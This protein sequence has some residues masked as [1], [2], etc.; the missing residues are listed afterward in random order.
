MAAPASRRRPCEAGKKSRFEVY[1]WRFTLESG[2]LRMPNP[3]R[4]AR[5]S[6]HMPLC[7]DHD[8]VRRTKDPAK[9]TNTRMA[10]VR[11]GCCSCCR[12]QNAAM[13]RT[14]ESG[15]A[16]T[17]MAGRQAAADGSS[18]TQRTCPR[19]WTC[20][21]CCRTQ[22][23]RRPGRRGTRPGRRLRARCCAISCCG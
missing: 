3:V 2:S 19:R 13:R 10:F 16:S 20:G 18:A 22:R 7:G 21:G 4:C 1:K 14:V 5:T 11:R 9:M 17:E 6:T 15:E 23:S 8:F 12:Q